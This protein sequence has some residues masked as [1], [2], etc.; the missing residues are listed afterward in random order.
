MFRKYIFLGLMIMLG[1]VLVMLVVQ[2][3]KQEAL[4]AQ[5]PAPAEIIRTARATATRVMAPRDLQITE[6]GGDAAGGA[7]AGTGNTP[8]AVIARQSIRNSGR[9]A[10]HNIMLKITC[11]GK[12]GKVLEI[13]TRL[14]PETIPSGLSRSLADLANEP[15]PDGTI[16]CTPSILYA[17]IG[18]APP[19]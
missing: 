14:L 8:S 17:E 5:T 18:A 1:A 2:G 11:L 19:Q 15:F 7:G 12:G 16:R 9:V 6:S 13:R 3:R 10:Y 4:R